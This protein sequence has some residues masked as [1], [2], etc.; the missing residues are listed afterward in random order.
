MGVL[1]E[2]FDLVLGVGQVR[3]V[4]RIVWLDGMVMVVVMMVVVLAE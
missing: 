4:D 2:V 3:V 1:V